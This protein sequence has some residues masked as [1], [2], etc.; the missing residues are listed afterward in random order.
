ME[1]MEEP[2]K[3]QDEPG[4]WISNVKRWDADDYYEPIR[5]WLEIFG[6][7]PHVQE[8]EY[9]RKDSNDSINS[10]TRT[11]I[12]NFSYN[13]NTEELLRITQHLKPLGRILKE[14][15]KNTRYFHL[16]ANIRRKKKLL[17]KICVHG[18]EIIE[19]CHIKKDIIEHFKYLCTRQEA[20]IFD[21]YTRG[22]LRLT[23]L[24]SQQLVEPIIVEE[25]KEV[26]LNCDPSKALGKTPIVG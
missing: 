10:I 4:L 7:T 22:L 21:I 2:L 13:D 14:G 18:E 26:I 9:P 17:E 15:D 3:N 25:I 16:V 6:V 23:E 12:A 1:E 11:K 20:T 19:P 8:S 24:Q 5:E